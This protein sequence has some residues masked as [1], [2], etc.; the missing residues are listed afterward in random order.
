MPAELFFGQRR[1][2]PSPGSC[3]ERAAGEA[4][5]P[6]LEVGDGVRL[7]NPLT[8]RWDEIGVVTGKRSTGRS[9]FVSREGGGRPLLRNRRFLKPLPAGEAGAVKPHS[10]SGGPA[11]TSPHLEEVTVWQPRNMG[12]R[13]SKPEPPPR[14]VVEE[15][16]STGFHVFELHMPTMGANVVLLVIVILAAIAVWRLRFCKSLRRRRG[17]RKAPSSDHY[18]LQPLVPAADSAANRSCRFAAAATARLRESRHCLAGRTIH[19]SNELDPCG[20]RGGGGAPTYIQAQTSCPS[21]SGIPRVSP[22]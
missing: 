22:I 13:K 7:Q 8:G 5:S 18:P 10:D 4:D 11:K 1:G 9:Y 3:G 15:E 19:A 14:E 16:T 6:A 12:P 21:L 20:L 17:S 2:I